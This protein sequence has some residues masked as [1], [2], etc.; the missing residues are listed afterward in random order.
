[1]YRFVL[2]VVLSL[3]SVSIASASWRDQI[4]SIKVGFLAGDNPAY[5][6]TRL[7]LFRQ[8]LQNGLAVKVELFPA[9]SY[10]ALIEAESS[11][12]IQY[13]IL[14]ATAY[15]ALD[16]ACH[17][18]E[19]LVQPTAGNGAQGFRAVLVTRADSPIQT[20]ADA[21]G[22]RLAIG[23]KDSISGRIAPFAAMAE[24]GIEPE[25][26]FARVF[27]TQDAA[28]ALT[29]LADGEADIAVAW[30]IAADPVS[31]EPGSGPI[32]DLAEQR[33][34]TM[35]GL[36]A[37]WTSELV[38]FGPHAIR[39]DLPPEARAALLD[40]LLQMKTSSPDA[41]DAAERQFS[42]GFVAA[43]STRYRGFAA[44]LAKLETPQ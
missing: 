18:A 4:A 3:A 10:Q 31:T 25:S 12:R 26:Y 27:E 33:D 23:A 16:Q 13:A 21:R 1:M 39:T 35:P 24:A 9:R 22:A 37:L 15:V 2:A 34:G 5:E 7:E 42:G 29:S 19:P 28:A 41:Y 44:L 43:D 36:R 38:P 11:G 14:S 6:V 32:A 17:C 40:T 20:L 8:A 30:S